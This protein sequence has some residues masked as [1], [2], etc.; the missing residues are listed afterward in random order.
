MLQSMGS[1]RA[2]HNL[3]TENNNMFADYTPLWVIKNWYLWF[4]VLYAIPSLPIYFIHLAMCF[5]GEGT[6]NPLQYSCLE[7]PMKRSLVGCCPQG[8]T[9]SETT[10]ATQ[11]ACMHWRGKW[12]STQMFVPG[13]SQG[14]WSLVRCCLCSRTESDTTEATQQQQQ[15]VSLGKW[16]YLS[17]PKFS[18]LQNSNLYL[19]H[20]P[21]TGIN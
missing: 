7:N 10:E 12:Q 21:V 11:H 3:V 19:N 1:Q 20:M 2:G 15:H 13:E 9:E 14:W 6:G 8:R 4:S 5:W 16:L 17:V 18:P